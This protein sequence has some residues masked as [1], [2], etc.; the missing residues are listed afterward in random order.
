MTREF[1][2]ANI[3]IIFF[4][5]DETL[6]IK[7]ETRI[8]SSILNE[9]L[10]RLRQ[11]GIIPAIATGRNYGGFPPALKPLLKS[12][13]NP[14]GFELFVTI[15]GQS[16]R[17]QQRFI[18]Q[19]PLSTERVEQVIAH[20]QQLDI[21]YAFVTDTEVAT[22]TRNAITDE[23]VLPIK[24]GYLIDP[25]YYKKD[26]V[27]QMLAFY[28]ESRQAEI[29]ASG[30]LG[31]DL[32]SVRWHAN[33]VDILA[34]QNSKARGIKDVLAHFGWTLDN[35]MAFG[36]GLNDLEMIANVGFGVAM[37]NGCDELKQLADF[38]TKPID[39]DG[40]LYALEQLGVI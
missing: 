38:V 25:D 1:N 9:V 2:P 13:Q 4:D 8:P 23:A 11:K 16:N 15:N 12:E 21:A 28:P 10:P 37:G 27:I 20:C 17:Y 6:Y 39:E 30:L 29:E 35:A 18:S 36:D 14:N 26:T 32:K 31:E 5:I 40:I 33:A 3:K 7:H 22:S 34:K 19:Y 24:K